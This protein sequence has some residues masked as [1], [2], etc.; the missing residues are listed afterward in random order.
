MK[1]ALKILKLTFLY[2]AKMVYYFMN[3]YNNFFIINVHFCR[4]G[5]ITFI[6]HFNCYSFTRIFAV[7]IYLNSSYRYKICLNISINFPLVQM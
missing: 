3:Y 4:L 7:F 6:F 1:T 2:T 5:I